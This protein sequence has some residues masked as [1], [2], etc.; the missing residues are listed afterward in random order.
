MYECW[1]I[2]VEIVELSDQELIHDG[3][4]GDGELL[5]HYARL[6]SLTVPPIGAPESV[7]RTIEM[8][9]AH[10][11]LLDGV[12]LSFFLPSSRLPLCC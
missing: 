6:P 4:M 5:R 12:S 8:A 11:E 1:L 7:R 3:F 2:S 10:P 9:R